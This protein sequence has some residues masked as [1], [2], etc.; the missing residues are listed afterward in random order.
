MRA[1]V[2]I[3]IGTQQATQKSSPSQGRCGPECYFMTGPK[4]E[5]RSHL[6][7]NACS[8]NKAYALGVVISHAA[9]P[10]HG[11][12]AASRFFLLQEVA[13]RA[14]GIAARLVRVGLL[15]GT[16]ELRFQHAPRQPGHIGNEFGIRGGPLDQER[17]LRAFAA[18]AI[19]AAEFAEQPAYCSGGTARAGCTC[20]RACKRCEHLEVE[21]VPCVNRP[22]ARQAAERG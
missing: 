5:W 13:E 22:R 16:A 7:S 8:R 1:R 2:P 11:A 14:K 19:R 20:R 3:P 6:L 9:Q 17:N 10:R 12:T 4:T 18:C 21:M 15:A